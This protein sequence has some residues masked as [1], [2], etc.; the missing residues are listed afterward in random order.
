MARIYTSRPP[1]PEAPGAAGTPGRPFANAPRPVP[2]AEPVEPRGFRNVGVLFCG[3][4]LLALLSYAHE[5]ITEYVGLNTHLP[6]LS[7][8]AATICA[9]LGGTLLRA[10]HT[11]TGRIWLAVLVWAVVCLPFSTWPSSSFDYVWSMVPLHLSVF[12]LCGLATTPGQVRKL[13]WWLIGGGMCLVAA[14]AVVGDTGVDRLVIPNT[15]LNNP[16]ELGLRLLL[17]AALMV[18]PLA[19][20]NRI[21]QVAGALGLLGLLMFLFRTGSRGSF[22]ALLIVL[23]GLFLISSGRTKVK[24]LAAAIIASAALAIVTPPASLERLTLM[25][26]DTPEAADNVP[27]DDADLSADQLGAAEASSMSRKELLKRGIRMT[28]EHPIFGVGPGQFPEIV[29]RDAKLRGGH[30]AAQRP[31]NAY[32]HASSEQGIPALILLVAVVG[33]SIRLNYRTYRRA[34]KQPGQS[35]IAI[36]SL[37]LFTYSLA[38]A[39]NMLFIHLL[40]VEELGPMVG[41]SLANALAVERTWEAQRTGPPAPF[42]MR[43]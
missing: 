16:N 12:F 30:I 39:S 17:G 23:V 40:S 34:Q 33:L 26:S 14:C 25:F 29:A 4:Y 9:M 37:A 42:R 24:L 35:L 20:P 3:V 22:V 11:R 13:I 18:F 36:Q 6:T 10:L 32:V 15:S 27:D 19:Y 8:Y 2:L 43:F 41:L 1:K 21:V 7:L 31:H 5:M 38:F 28:L